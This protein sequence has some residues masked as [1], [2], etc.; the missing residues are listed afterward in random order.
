MTEYAM[1]V[2]PNSCESDCGMVVIFDSVFSVPRRIRTIFN[3]SEKDFKDMRLN[4]NQLVDAAYEEMSVNLH[5]RT[6]ELIPGKKI[7]FQ[8][9][10]RF[11][12]SFVSVDVIR[13]QHDETREV[14]YGK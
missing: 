2:A 6:L 10:F 7:P 13:N 9:A 5:E 1:K 11:H 14:I 3:D 8:F 12:F 4:L